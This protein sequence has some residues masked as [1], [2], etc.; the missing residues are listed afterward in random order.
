MTAPWQSGDG[1][2]RRRALEHVY[3]EAMRDLPV[4]KIK[5]GWLVGS[6]KILAQKKTLKVVPAR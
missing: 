6:E 1:A 2:Y 3:K 4:G 5:P